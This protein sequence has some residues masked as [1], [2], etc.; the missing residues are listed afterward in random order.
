MYI[1]KMMNMGEVDIKGLD[2]NFIGNTSAGKDL[3]SSAT[4]S[5]QKAIDITDPDAK[6]TKI[7]YLILETFGKCVAN[8]GESVGQRLL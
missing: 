5:F 7:R 3:T 4:Y 2:V 1:W 8:L 6:I